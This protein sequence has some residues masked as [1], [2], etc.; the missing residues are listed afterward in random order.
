MAN[1]PDPLGL[2]RRLDDLDATRDQSDAGERD[3]DV[4]GDERMAALPEHERDDDQSVGGGLASAGG[5]A[6]DRGTG[7]LEGR[8]EQHD[9]A[10]KEREGGDPWTT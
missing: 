10:E 9:V 1:L 5:T 3:A 8:A 7:T 2:N 4:E 6:V